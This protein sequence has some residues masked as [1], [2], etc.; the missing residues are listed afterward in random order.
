MKTITDIENFVSERQWVQHIQHIEPIGAGEYNENYKITSST[1]NYVFRINHGSQLGIDNQIEYEFQTLKAL[2]H[3]GVTPNVYHYQLNSPID[4]KGV[5]LM[6]FLPGT[7]L[8]YETDSAKAATIFSHIHRQPVADHFICQQNPVMDIV[9]ECE[10]LIHTYPKHPLKSQKQLLLKYKDKITDL[11]DT[12]LKQFQTEPMCIV[13]TEVNSGNFLMNDTTSYLIDWEK[14]VVSY[15]YQDL[16]HFICPTTTL[17]KTDTRYTEKQKIN[18]ITQY[19]DQMGLLSEID[20]LCENTFLMEKVI[21]LRA[22]SW[23]Y[24]AF[25]EYTQQER[26]LKN[27][28]TFEKIKHY[29]DNMACFLA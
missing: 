23:C 11:A 10:Q 9:A 25:Y 28:G 2:K 15:R 4:G 8:S 29:M 6:D 27:S 17:W 7:P 19:A 13:N 3:S 16:A 24:M 26:H 1:S 12:V 20:Q 18:F 14:A 5:L 22:M 21:L